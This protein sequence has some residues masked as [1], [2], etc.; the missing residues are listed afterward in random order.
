VRTNIFNGQRNRVPSGGSA[1]RDLSLQETIDG[2]KGKVAAMEPGD[3]ARLVAES[4]LD[5]RLY[6]ITHPSLFPP[7]RVRHEA[8]AAAHGASGR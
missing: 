2:F 6:A 4:I 8:I 3:V 7:V 5:G 1:L